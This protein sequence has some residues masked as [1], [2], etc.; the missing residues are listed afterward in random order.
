MDDREIQYAA[1]EMHYR[2]IA[3]QAFR[4]IM[5][6]GG[7]QALDRFEG[8]AK[9]QVATIPRLSPEFAKTVDL[10]VQAFEKDLDLARDI[11]DLI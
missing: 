10:A 11:P 5:E 4:F 1:L 7:P 9:H 6:L 2:G 3:R 8:L